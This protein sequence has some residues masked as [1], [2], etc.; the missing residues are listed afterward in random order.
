MFLQPFLYH[1]HVKLKIKN[2]ILFSHSTCVSLSVDGGLSISSPPWQTRLFLHSSY[3]CSS[4]FF[5]WP[6]VF[7]TI[8]F[9]TGSLWVIKRPKKKLY[10]MCVMAQSFH[11]NCFSQLKDTVNIYR[12]RKETKIQNSAKQFI[13]L[14]SVASCI[15]P[16]PSPPPPTS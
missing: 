15:V 13:V 16:P 3:T 12:P 7:C 9:T 8:V 10:S 1:N 6:L 14:H 4:R 5:G 2:H 11:R